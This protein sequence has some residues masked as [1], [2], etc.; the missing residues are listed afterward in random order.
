MSRDLALGRMKAGRMNQTEAA[1]A[2]LL[3]SQKQAGD[4][5]WYAFE[6]MTFKLADNTRYTPDFN[7]MRADGLMEI[8]EVKG[9]WRD[10]GR[11]KIK[12][13]AEMFPFRFIAVKKCAQKDGGG[14][15]REIF[16]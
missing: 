12:V 11:V 10:D 7:V 5:V 3:E 6:G 9:F 13:A 4:I 2:R 1:Y 8:H 16:E 14:W 15:E